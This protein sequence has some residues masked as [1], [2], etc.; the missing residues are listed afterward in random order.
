MITYARGKRGFLMVMLA[1]TSAILFTT[2][3]Y[4]APPLPFHTIEGVGGGAITPMAYLVNPEPRF[5]GA[6]LGK[7]A[8]A[9]SYVNMGKKNL[10]AL[11]ITETIGGRLELGYA[12]DRLGLGTLPGAIQHATNVDIQRGDVW[13]HHFN[14]RFMAVKENSC[15]FGL[16][17]PAITAGVH[18]KVND[19]IRDINRRLNGVISQIGCGRENGVD[20]T[21]T[22]TRAIPPEI[23]GCP[24]MV[25]GG[26]RASQAAQLGFL[27]FC[28]DYRATFEGN[29]VVLPCDNWVLAYE[30]R[31]K[32]DPYGQIPGL[33]GNEDHWHAFDVAYILSDHATLVAGYGMFGTLCD[34]EANNAWWLQLKYEF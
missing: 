22:A 16:S 34:T 25:T 3:A 4:A 31:Q 11:T 30:F 17:M 23:L 14:A 5:E 32:P 15:L 29:I 1:I 18:C 27:G 7:P 8:V 9:F 10:D 21:I 33:I 13:L 12:A 26:L 2:A 6:M 28:H 19:G 20:F 24:V